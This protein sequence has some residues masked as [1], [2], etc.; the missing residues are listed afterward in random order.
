MYQVNLTYLSSFALTY[1]VQVKPL[2]GGPCD[3]QLVGP[4][5]LGLAFGVLVGGKEL[6]H[7]LDFFP[8]Q[9]RGP[10]PA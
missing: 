6:V 10:Q 2:R 5:E 9:Q 3:L 1:R 7:Q 8:S 4:L